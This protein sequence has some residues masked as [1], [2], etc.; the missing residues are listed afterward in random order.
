MNG[1][2]RLIF[3]AALLLG[4]CQ[5]SYAFQNTA[6]DQD[7]VPDS[8]VQMKRKA[9]DLIVTGYAKEAS[10]LYGKLR[11]Y[12]YD[13][14]YEK[15]SLN[16]LEYEFESIC[17]D[18]SL[19]ALERINK[20]KQ[21]SDSEQR[22][23]TEGVYYTYVSQVYFDEGNTDS[24]K[25]FY[26]KA[27][28][29]LEQYGQ[30]LQLCNLELM[31]A[32]YYYAFNDLDNTT[33]HLN[34]AEKVID[35]YLKPNSITV[36]TSFLLQKAAVLYDQTKLKKAEYY[37]LKGIQEI[38]N[39]R[40]I[41]EKY[42]MNL[43]YNTALLYDKMSDFD[44]CI[45]Y[46][47]KCIETA[48]KNNYDYIDW[49]L[50]PM[51]YMGTSYQDKGDTKRA[52]QLYLEVAQALKE[53]PQE[54]DLYNGLLIE[55]YQHLGKYYILSKQYDSCR[56][57]LNQLEGIH[58]NP[59]YQKHNTY[60]IALDLDI[61]TKS[62]QAAW[63]RL[64][65]YKEAL[66]ERGKEYYKANLHDCHNK[67]AQIALLEN[68]PQKALSYCQKNLVILSPKF[69]EAEAYANPSCTSID[70]KD[71]IVEVLP[72]KIRVLEILYQQKHPQ[73]T[74]ELLL[75]TIKLAIQGIEYKNN[76]FKTKSSQRYWLN[77]EAIPLF[78]KAIGI[79]LNI[80]E[81]TDDKHYLNEAFQLSEQSK[82]MMLRSVLQDE[83]AETF[84]G[85][86]DSLVEKEQ[87]LKQQLKITEKQRRD[88][89]LANNNA[90]VQYLDNLIFDYHNQKTLLLHKFEVNYP[91]YY[92]L[93]HQTRKINIIDVQQ[94]IDE[95]TAV[96]E[97]FQ[98]KEHIY[99]FTVTKEQAF[100]RQ[101]E[102]TKAY[103]QQ[104]LD[105]QRQLTNAKGAAQNL[106]QARQ[107]MGHLGFTLYQ[108]LV[109]DNLVKGK[110]RLMFILDGQLGYLPFEALLTEPVADQGSTNFAT[111]PYLLRTHTIHY[112]YSALLLL[113]QRADASRKAGH[114]I[115]AFAPSY[116]NKKAPEWRNP[117]ERQLRQRLEELPGATQEFNFL[118]RHFGGLFLNKEK[119]SETA[120]KK[121]ASQYDIL[122]LA[123]HG[124]VDHEKPE[125]S[126]LALEEDNSRQEDN[127]LY[128]YE[129]KQLDLKAQLVVLS[130]C[131]TGNGRYQR[132]E[133]VLSIGRGFM[134]AGVPSLLTTLW[135]LN[136]DT[137][138]FII[139]QFYEN[140][141]Q[142]MD[143]DEA[144]RQAKLS[145]LD[146]RNGI[147]AHPALWACFVQV[148]DYSS[149][150]IAP[151]F[152]WY[153]YLYAG[154]GLLVLVALFFVYK[155]RKC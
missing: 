29:F 60:R 84:G 45:L 137:G 121:N 68:N 20:L 10:K 72:M 101:F 3:A 67:A 122:H 87:W 12:C 100:A 66:Y 22:Y 93:K 110:T 55:T 119:A 142:G 82:S 6:F 38:E 28:I 130:A 96:I 51:L 141:R 5:Y 25:Y 59:R 39:D 7:G 27:V 102:R 90:Q 120:F 16:I 151:P 65:Q 148:G 97:Y 83:T 132:G 126:G 152:I 71:K 127:I 36:P 37:Y 56:Y 154:L 125:L 128:A 111:L 40:T 88:A 19:S 24:S 104:I 53:A 89:A 112:N 42:L 4:Y 41:G 146:N 135:S 32:S 144:I 63:I 92:E 15:M 34:K 155:T 145:Y 75:S 69:S 94:A 103:D 52:K 49:V 147:A 21:Y 2:V 143:K 23:A 117:Y 54:T 35:N 91:K 149:L 118:K 80:Y 50:Y 123:V 150:E 78:E 85:I 115:L 134:Y 44:N 46:Y 9:Y 98:G 106:R 140:L 136:D 108:Q 124:I 62:P 86:P 138:A 116:S 113:A 47:E 26:Q 131:E 43:Y 105:F 77:R 107:R 48:L 114:K 129:I 17:Y 1:I 64:G 58:K 11:N 31:M 14:G 73:V 81:Q 13:L 153:H 70:D 109:K 79:A 30:H 33:M 8:L 18:G 95:R 74:P 57:Y 61:N 139:E 99:V 133:G 76:Q